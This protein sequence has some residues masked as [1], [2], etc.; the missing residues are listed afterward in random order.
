M[1]PP[2]VKLFNRN[3]VL[4]WI[5]LSDLSSTKA[6]ANDKTVQHSWWKQALWSPW[7]YEKGIYLD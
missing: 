6:C 4:Y 5:K 3:T 7:K 1:T 2:S